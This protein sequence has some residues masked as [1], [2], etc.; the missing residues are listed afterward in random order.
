M[1]KMAFESHEIYSICKTHL[2]Y[3]TH[4]SATSSL[5]SQ[6]LLCNC[7]TS[8]ATHVYNYVD[9]NK[10]VFFACLDLHYRLKRFCVLLCCTLFCA[11]LP[12]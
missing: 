4:V 5:Q 11:F 2:V 10:L 9:G 1:H 12:I 7:M 8:E 3:K 6:I